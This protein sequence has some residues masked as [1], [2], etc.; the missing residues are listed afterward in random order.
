MKAQRFWIFGIF[1]ITDFSAQLDLP[2][3][4]L[5]KALCIVHL[6]AK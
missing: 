4:I 6:Q 2:E 1:I 3:N 5:A